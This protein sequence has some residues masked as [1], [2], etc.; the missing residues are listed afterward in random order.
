MHLAHA[1]IRLNAV[2]DHAGGIAHLVGDVVEEGR[3]GRPQLR[4]LDG[5]HGHGT[6]IA[7]HLRLCHHLFAVIDFYR[8]S[9]GCRLAEE[10]RMN[11]ELLL[12]DVGHG[13]YRLQTLGIDR[14]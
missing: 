1:G 3:F 11:D 14:L 10:A 12:V 8:Q 2:D 6:V 13:E 9:V 4:L 7:R 5:Q